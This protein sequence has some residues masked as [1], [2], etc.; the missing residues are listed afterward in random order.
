MKI[1]NIGLWVLICLTQNSV[2]ETISFESMR[3]FSELYKDFYRYNIFQQIDPTTQEMTSF[4]NIQSI[5]PSFNEIGK[6]Y[7]GISKLDLT[8]YIGNT[9]RLSIDAEPNALQKN[10]SGNGAHLYLKQTRNARP[11]EKILNDYDTCMLFFDNSDNRPHTEIGVKKTMTVISHILPSVET[12]SIG[13]WL[14]GAG[15]ITFSNFRVEII[16]PSTPELTMEP[17]GINPTENYWCPTLD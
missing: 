4:L 14:E 2:A 17:W 1:L 7:G 3:Y 9:V 11:G 13:F 10:Y 8:P 15:D 5:E 16:D 12:I 6:F